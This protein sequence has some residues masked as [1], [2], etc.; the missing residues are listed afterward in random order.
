MIYPEKKVNSLKYLVMETFKLK[1]KSKKLD[2]GRFQV[3]FSTE[4]FCDHFYGYLLAEPKTPFREV[5]E[6]IERHVEAM[7]CSDRYYQRNLFSLIHR[8]TNSGRILIFK[9]QTV[10]QKAA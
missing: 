4:G 1:I 2:S 9:S 7:R 3:H 6:K 8:E 10:K 5:V